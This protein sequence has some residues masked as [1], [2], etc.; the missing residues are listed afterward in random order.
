VRVLVTGGTGFIGKYVCENLQD[1]GHEPITFGVTKGCDVLGDIRDATA[2]D[3]AVSTC[4]AVMHLAGVLGTQETVDDP[5][6]AIET[7]ILGGLN[8]F[9]TIRRYEVPAVNIAAANHWMWN[10]YSVTKKA[11][12]RFALMAN[13][14]WG[15]R[16]AL[17]RGLNVYGPRQKAYPVK[18]IMPNLILPALEGRPIVIY[19][20]GEQI[21]DMIWVEDVA[22]ILVRGLL[23]DHGVMDAGTGRRTTVNQLAEMVIEMVGRGEIHHVPMRPGEEEHA[24]V[25]GDPST[26]GPLGWALED[27]LS[28]EDGLKRTIASYQ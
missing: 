20:D 5:L 27:F 4:D 3:I 21:M 23:V 28:L 8:V 7:N 2:L 19:G 13:K 18:K 26:L 22:E 9:K 6:P 24:E 10:P 1:K 15:T 17:I 25:L 12:E 16:I 14:E 11:A